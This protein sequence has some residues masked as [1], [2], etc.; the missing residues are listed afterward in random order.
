LS[1]QSKRS[2]DDEI[3]ATAVTE[4][5]ETSGVL[6]VS[7]CDIKSS[8][9][10]QQSAP[11]KRDTGLGSCA[12]SDEEPGRCQL[13]APASPPELTEGLFSVID[14][15]RFFAHRV[16]PSFHAGPLLW[17]VGPAADPE[18]VLQAPPPEPEPT[19]QREPPTGLIQS[20]YITD[21]TAVQRSQG[22]SSP[23]RLTEQEMK[24]EVK[25]STASPKL[26]ASF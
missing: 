6:S 16:W 9:R 11:T 19:K 4:E 18:H 22:S 8:R 13:V 12:A 21:E 5:A 20:W 26:G 2:D 3:I 17:N 15:V 7:V 25:G 14:N 1:E 10:P 24:E 23:L